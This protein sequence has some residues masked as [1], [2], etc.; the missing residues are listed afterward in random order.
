M[1]FHQ[2]SDSIAG[3]SEK[4]LA[5]ANIISR[6]YEWG[7]CESPMKQDDFSSVDVASEAS[8]LNA[9]SESIAHHSIAIPKGAQGLARF[10][11]F[12]GPAII[13]SVGYMDPGNWGTDIGAGSQF[14]Y[15]LLW[16][17]VLSGL[18]AIFLQNLSARLGVAGNVDLANG[19]RIRY[20][21]RWKIPL[22][23]AAQ[24][25]IVACDLAEVIGSAVALKL[26]FH[27]PLLA[28]VFITALDVLL[29]LMLEKFGFRKIEAIVLSLVAII[30]GCF[31]FELALCRPEW[32][33]VAVHS[34][35]PWMKGKDAVL[36]VV[37]IVGA[38]VMPHNLYLHSALVRTR[39][40]TDTKEAL[41]MNRL[42]TVIALG[43]ATVVNAAILILAA[44]TFFRAGH[45]NV[46]ELGDAHALLKPLLGGLAPTVFAIG[47]LAAG[48]SSTITGT[49]AGQVVM[50]G[51]LGLKIKPAYQRLMTRGL[52]I[53]PAA[54][55]I[56][57][58]GEGNT[59][60]L[61]VLSQIILSMQL[62]F[63]IFP[64]VAMTGDKKLMGEHATSKFVHLVGWILG[65]LILLLNVVLIFQSVTGS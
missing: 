47:L 24:I 3:K 4:S 64:L 49:M 15:N 61:L 52:A 16:I 8:P 9:G 48:Q 22:W 60:G 17:V 44:A 58:K 38:T 55:V 31:I 18:A 42:D 45:F 1:H 51:L 30:A 25:A 56:A 13:V 19:C 23:I 65:I 62:P 11:A 5:Y 32:D 6:Y 43:I 39:K 27:I 54:L 14:N 12:A 57:V 37:G 41:R 36:L 35:V 53:V 29:I 59:M 21:D 10:L 63:A 33:Q 40:F 28:G 7:F 34:V 26:L 50:E 2:I 46:Q 20:G